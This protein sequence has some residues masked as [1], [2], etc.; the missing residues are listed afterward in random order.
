M[1][2]GGRGFCVLRLP[3]DPAQPL[4]GVVGRTGWPVARPLEGEPELAQLRSQARQIETVLRVIRAR[5]ERLEASR[6]PA[7]V[8]G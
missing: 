4:L 5:L 3:S 1:T 2:G 7:T 8:G 6:R